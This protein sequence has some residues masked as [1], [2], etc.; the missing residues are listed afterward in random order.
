MRQI[1]FD[2]K[3][4]HRILDTFKMLCSD[5]NRD[6][7]IDLSQAMLKNYQ[8]WCIESLE[9]FKYLDKK[10]SCPASKAYLTWNGK[11]LLRLSY[12]IHMGRI[13]NE[14]EIGEYFKDFNK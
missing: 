1:S 5:Y 7:F 13:E 2:N 10:E 14:L 4:A 3:K 6:G 11:L 9:L 12:L 8:D